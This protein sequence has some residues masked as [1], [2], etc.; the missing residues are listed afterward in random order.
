MRTRAT[1]SDHTA[2]ER[3]VVPDASELGRKEC[4]K[5]VAG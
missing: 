5:R 1:R 4:T 2:L 3:A